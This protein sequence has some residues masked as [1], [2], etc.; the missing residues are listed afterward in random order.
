MRNYLK[1]VT[2]GA[3]TW[4]NEGRIA[5]LFAYIRKT[6]VFYLVLH[7]FLVTLC[8]NF[9]LMVGVTRLSPYQLYTRMYGDNF[10][11]ALPESVRE[12]FTGDTVIAPVY[13]D[14]FNIMMTDNGYGRNVLLPLL[15]IN[16][17]IILIIQAVFYLCSAIFLGL[18]RMNVAPITFRN[19]F[20]LA[21]F[22]STLPVL[23]ASVIGLVL[24]AVHVVIFYFIVIFLVFQ[25][26]SLFTS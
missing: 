16:L 15:G 7:F 8:L 13:I 19:R 5:L 1:T 11:Y 3:F 2:L 12:A 14:D 4:R 17:V 24:P 25:R 22:S 6:G 23:A 21:V 26:S 10:V 18:S 9:P 20:G